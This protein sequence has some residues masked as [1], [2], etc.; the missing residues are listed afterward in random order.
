MTTKKLYADFKKIEKHLNKNAY[1]KDK[2]NRLMAKH[3]KVSEELGELT[4]EIL[5]KLG[6]Q[7][8]KEKQQNFKN[9]NIENEWF[10]VLATVILLGMEL[11]I[12]IEELSKKRLREIKKRL[13]IIKN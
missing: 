1:P 9:E 12:D 6:Y 3:L 2:A 5:L 7:L 8:R 10:D 11:D 4:D 13:N